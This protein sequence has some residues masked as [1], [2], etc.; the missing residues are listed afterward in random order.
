MDRQGRRG[1]KALMRGVIRMR[2]SLLLAV[3]VAGMKG[4]MG[5]WP[6]DIVSPY[7]GI[8]R[9]GTTSVN[10]TVSFPAH[11]TIEWKTTILAS[12]NDQKDPSIFAYRIRRS[13][14]IPD[15]L[16]PKQSSQMS[17]SSNEM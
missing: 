5:G 2:L 3:E 7:P 17:F 16:R 11:L 6:G 10:A 9:L 14:T 15:S 8:W 13:P 12:T 4:L 1:R